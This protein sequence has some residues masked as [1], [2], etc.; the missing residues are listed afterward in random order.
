MLNLQIVAYAGTCS[1]AMA[2]PVVASTSELTSAVTCGCLQDVASAHLLLLAAVNTA[3][4]VWLQQHDAVI[5][6]C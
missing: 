5:M 3:E 4:V 2:D 6:H 1:P